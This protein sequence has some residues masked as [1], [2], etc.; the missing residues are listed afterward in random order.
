MSS[1]VCINLTARVGQLT[2]CRGAF[3]FALHSC[4]VVADNAVVVGAR[5]VFR[6]KLA[7]FTP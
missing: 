1:S 3:D 7:T 2:I 6:G 5:Q 4:F